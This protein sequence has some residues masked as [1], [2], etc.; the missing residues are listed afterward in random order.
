[1]AGIVEPQEH[2]GV[3]PVRIEVE[4]EA[5]LVQPAHDRRDE[6]QLERPHD[7][8]DDFAHDVEE[9]Q[10]IFVEPDAE[11]RVRQRRRRRDAERDQH[12]PNDGCWFQAARRRRW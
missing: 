7:D 4:L 12:D 1:M 9:Q 6:Q 11:G 10:E 8:A 5:L 2:E 3:L